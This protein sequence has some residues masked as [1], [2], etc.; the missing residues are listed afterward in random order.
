MHTSVLE[1][2]R[3]DGRVALVT[4]GARGLGRTM[5]TALAEAGADIALAG[6][7]VE[8]CLE[9]ADGIAK[10]TGRRAVAFAADVTKLADIE[11]LKAEVDTALGKIDILVNNAGVNIRG[12][13]NQLTEAD[14]DTVIDTNLKGPFLCARTVGPAMVKRGWGRVVSLASVLGK[15]ALPGRAPYASSKAGVINLTRVLALEWAGTGVAAKA[16]CRGDFATEL[17]RL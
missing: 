11:R 10:A 8:S 16:I 12:P 3:L 7:S 17:N 2:F 4:G 1:S 9:A 13:I 5:A 14:W 6:R 15:I